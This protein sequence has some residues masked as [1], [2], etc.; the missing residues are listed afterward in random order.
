MR[1]KMF[2]LRLF[3][4]RLKFSRPCL[5]SNCKKGEWT[6]QNYLHSIFFK[7]FFFYKAGTLLNKLKITF[8]N[9]PTIIFCAIIT[10]YTML[11]QEIAAELPISGTGWEC[12]L[13]TLP[14]FCY[15]LHIPCVCCHVPLGGALGFCTSEITLH[16]KH[17]IR[18]GWLQW[19]S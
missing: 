16:L 12:A 8:S 15:S 6:M 11:H 14:C 13:Q 9:T 1:W 2:W 7:A 18:S 5:I 3:W 4:L 10:T 19:K 17:K